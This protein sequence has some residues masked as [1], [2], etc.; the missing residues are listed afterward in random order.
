MIKE[1]KKNTESL[2]IKEKKK[3]NSI[4]SLLITIGPMGI[5]TT[6][7]FLFPFIYVLIISFCARNQYGNILYE[8]TLKAYETLLKP[9]YYT[10]I[11]R[12]VFM[13]FIVTLLVILIAYPYAY[14]ASRATKSIQK[15]MIIGIIIPFW[16][17]ALLRVYAIMNVTSKNGI[18]NTLLV[19]LGVIDEPIQILYTQFA[20]YFGLIYSL[21]PLMVMP[22][23]SSLQ[24]IDSAVLEAGRDLGASSI[25]LF[26][27]VIFP[28]SVPGIMGGVVLVFVPS[29]FN[30]YVPD[31]LGGGKMIVIGNV[32]SNQFSVSKNW[33]F[34][35]ALSVV[36][37]L[38]SSLIIMLNN[39]LANVERGVK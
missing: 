37:M 30:F 10:V 15:L 2:K 38:F 34:G 36:V 9:V 24:K 17:N 14:I 28:L 23:Y 12:T 5:W 33:P 19:N 22:L 32:I 39:K 11:Y 1:K 27:K 26:C 7:F 16:T 4:P 29:M 31:A 13:A 6:V 35:A 3:I 18:I 25:Q 8:F 21:M 20:V